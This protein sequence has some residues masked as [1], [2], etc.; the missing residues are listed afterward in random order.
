MEEDVEV[1]TE[2]VQLGL[3]GGE[4]EVD[5][6][7]AE[8][9]G[10]LDVGQGGRVGAAGGELVGGHLLGDL[11]DVGAAV[12]VLGGLLAACGGQQGS[13]EAVDLG[14]VVVE[15]VLPCDLGPAGGQDPGQGVADCGPA[16]ATQVDRPGGVG[17]DVLEVD[18]L[19]AQ[20]VVAAVGLSGLDDG[21]GEL[22]GAGGVEADVE[23]SGAGDLHGGDA[24]E[25]LKTRD[26]EL[27]EIARLS[28]RL[29]GQLHGH[30]GGPVAVVAVAGTLD[31][32]VGD[33]G[34]GQGEGALGGGL[35]QDG[36]DGCGKL[37]WG[38]ARQRTVNGRTGSR[39]RPTASGHRGTC[40]SLV[41]V[42]LR[43]RDAGTV[44][45]RAPVAQWIERLPPEQK[46]AGSNPVRGTTSEPS[47]TSA[48]GAHSCVLRHNSPGRGGAQASSARP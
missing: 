40:R 15:V 1:G 2:G 9:L 25:G 38:H 6:A 46:V 30:V 48:A 47:S 44:T 27:G 26:E 19:A 11:T 23:E 21:A 35:L 17:R 42:S 39:G 20:G 24:V 13:G 5:A 8:D 18:V 37:F 31:A 12:A 22:A 28:A 41:P 14:T 7:G 34:G 33:L 3:D 10:G 29:L 32:R 45:P 36:A 16:S 4:H 43:D